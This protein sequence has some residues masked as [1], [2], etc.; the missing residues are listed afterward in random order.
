LAA[1]GGNT[2][3]DLQAGAQPRFLGYPVVFADVMNS[4]LTAQTSTDGLAYFGNLRMAGLFG[5]RRGL[6]IAT[7]TDVYF[8]TDDVGVRATER[9]D[10]NIHDKGDA[11]NAGG[12]VMLSTPG[13]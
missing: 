10:V 2:I 4:T 9:F 7:S 12:I 1:A 6:A 13:S 5:D 8:T 3:A 11:S